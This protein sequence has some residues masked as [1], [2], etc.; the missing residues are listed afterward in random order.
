MNMV[1]VRTFKVKFFTRRGRF[2]YYT[3]LAWEKADRL[4]EGGKVLAVLR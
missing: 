1:G 2:W 3:N 4:L